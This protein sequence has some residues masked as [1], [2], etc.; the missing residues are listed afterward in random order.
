MINKNVEK[1]L[2]EQAQKEEFSARFYL[3]M[4]IW[5]EV[6]GYSGAATFLYNHT[7]EERMHQ[8]K[9]IHF[10]NERGGKAVL[11]ELEA[12]KVEFNS[13]QDIFTQVLTHEEFV[14]NAI[15][16]LYGLTIEEKD[17]TTGNFL[18]WYI[19]EQLEEEN[20]MRT[21]LD[22]I[23][24]VGK[25]KAGMFHIDKELDAMAQSSVAGNA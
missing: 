24:L 8:M 11:F 25:D 19:T 5:C 1:M 12:P 22:K 7:N 21:I 16:E 9:I 17:Y 13:L 6:N 2:N 3:A 14:T 18:Q 15:N 4:A 10:I 20:T 23:K